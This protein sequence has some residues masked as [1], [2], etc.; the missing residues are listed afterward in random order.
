MFKSNP[1][2]FKDLLISLN[3]KIW[4]NLIIGFSILYFVSFL[5]LLS[6][7]KNSYEFDSLSRMGRDI[8]MVTWVVQML[9]LIF[10]WYMKWLTSI[11]LEKT[12]KTFNFI[13]ISPINWFQFILWKF[14][15]IFIYILLLFFISLPFLS[16]WLLLWWV[17]ITDVPVY[18]LY[19]ITSISISILFWL[20]LSILSK[21]FS[22]VLWL[23]I[24]PIII[25]F[26]VFHFI[27]IPIE[28]LHFWYST[29]S[30]S[31][32]VWLFPMEL[33][34]GNNIKYIELFWINIHYIIY[35]IVFYSTIFLLLSK[36][37]VK[38]YNTNIKINTKIYSY[39]E[40]ILLF[41][42]FLLLSPLYW[43]KF[44]YIIY[45]FIIINSLFFLF[46]DNLIKKWEYIEFL[47]YTIFSSSLWIITL[48]LINGFTI[49]TIILYLT[50]IITIYSL[51]I[52]LIKN[53]I[54]I[55]KPLINLYLFVSL[56]IFFYILP[57]LF[58]NI[59]GIKYLNINDLL[60][61][62]YY[63]D[64][65]SDYCEKDY[66]LRN[67]YKEFEC[68]EIKNNDLKKYILFY[69]LFSSILLSISY[70]RTKKGNK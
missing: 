12:N 24:V 9:L 32:M 45:L 47:K 13:K 64:N 19:S 10:I 35:H 34:E 48:I 44:F 31:L 62:S 61:I 5:L 50:I 15:S 69:L 66:R 16:I 37:L 1:I 33:F 36:I 38:Q 11:T 4:K 27:Y 52:F 57:A 20:L 67:D 53:I 3:W 70:I 59:L 8:F 65:L 54:K 25:F 42:I 60:N 63:K 56:T 29:I 28:A 55:I 41:I 6:E 49:Y 39:L 51:Y 68:T 40:I 17:S 22:I 23:W 46:S 30:D 58:T 2:L 18:I 43:D 21:K 14:L 7:T 26:I